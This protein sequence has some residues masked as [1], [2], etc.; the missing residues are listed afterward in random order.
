MC[1]W[2]PRT[3]R[4]LRPTYRSFPMLI[5]GAELGNLQIPSRAGLG[6]E[7]LT[8]TDRKVQCRR[9]WPSLGG[10]ATLPLLE[11]GWN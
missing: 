3:Q 6:L 5:T 7:L 10:L 11:L 9:S 2:A 1:R 8:E 4:P